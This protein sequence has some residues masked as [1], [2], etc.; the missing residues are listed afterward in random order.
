MDQ[1]EVLAY[2]SRQDVT[3]ALLE[4]SR[5]REVVGR[6]R[7]GGY[8]SRPSTLQHEGDIIRL[9]NQGVTSFHASVELWKH[10]MALD[11]G[12]EVRLGWDLVID[13]DCPELEK[14]KIVAVNVIEALK[15]HGIRSIYAKYSGNKGFHI[16]VPWKA[17]HPALVDRFPE[18]PRA[19]ALYL[20]NL[21][22][23]E[24][25]SDI[26][27][28]MSI[29]TIAMA[30]R[31]LIRAPYS[32][33]EK[34]WLVSVPV[35]LN[36]IEDFEKEEARPELVRARPWIFEAREKEAMLLVDLALQYLAKPVKPRGIKRVEFKGKVPF[37]AFPP[38]I[39]LILNGLKDGRKRSE[40]ILRTF[41]RAS[42]YDWEEVE[43]M[44]FEWNK[45]NAK[46]LREGYIRSE[47]RWHKKQEEKGR[48]LLPPNCDKEGFYKDIGICKPDELCRSIRNPIAYAFKRMRMLKHA[49]QEGKEGEEGKLKSQESK[50]G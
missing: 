39:K 16:Y 1:E 3:Q 14:S 5:N 37:E 44:L 35:E 10:P 31:H 22:Q 43:A 26:G 4:F 50:N 38:C 23:E 6:F 7:D 45:K 20:F 17:F 24:L 27:N 29:D 46:P 32:L 13:I 11:T 36:H 34:T 15:A 48:F 2:Y 8:A 28:E 12:K 41:L 47:I 42:G 30:S 25:P 9:V 18:I 19:I 49:P 33:H 40:F 21:M